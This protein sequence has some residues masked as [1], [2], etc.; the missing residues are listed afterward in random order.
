MSSVSRVGERQ[1]GRDTRSLRGRGCFRP[2]RPS[3]GAVP[4]HGR[5]ASSCAATCSSV[6]S[7]SGWP[8]SCTALGSPSSPKPDGQRQRGLAGDVEQRRERREAAGARA[9]RPAAARRSRRSSP[10]GSGRVGERPASAARRSRRRTRPCGARAPAAARPRRGS[11]VEESVAGVLEHRARQR[12]DLVLGR[13]PPGE[14]ARRSRSR[15]RP[16]GRRRRGRCRASPRRAAA[17]ASS[18]TSCPSARQRVGRV[19][20]PAHAPPG[21]RRP[22]AA[23]SSVIATR[24]RPGSRR[25]ASVYG[26]AGFG[27]QVASPAS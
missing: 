4:A 21:R 12:L 9:G 2:R 16:S 19:V 27:A 17:G 5:A 1:E 13:R 15:P 26:S 10:I 7:P 14:R 18:T 11:A 23:F 3:P 25:I 8:T 6:S 22:R 24:S 20:Q